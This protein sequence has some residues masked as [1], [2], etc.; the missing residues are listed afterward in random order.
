MQRRRIQY[1]TQGQTHI[2]RSHISP[3]AIIDIDDSNINYIN[4]TSPSTERRRSQCKT[5]KG[6]RR[7]KAYADVATCRY[8][9]R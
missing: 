4:L 1:P 5:A 6:D 9:V 7:W 2:E 3:K 8:E